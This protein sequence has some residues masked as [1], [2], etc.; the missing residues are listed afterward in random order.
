VEIF[1]GGIAWPNSTELSAESDIIIHQVLE[2]L[3]CAI[4]TIS[5]NLW[6]PEKR[7]IILAFVIPKYNWKLLD[8]VLRRDFTINAFLMSITTGEFGSFL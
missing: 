5:W 8:D 4:K 7:N 1:E 3:P 2:L 6:L